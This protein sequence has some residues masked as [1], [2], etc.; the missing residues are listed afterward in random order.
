MRQ[1]MIGFR[2]EVASAGPYASL[3]LT[4]DRQPHQLLISQFL[5]AGYSSWRPTNIVKA[6]KA[7]TLHADKSIKNRV[8]YERT[9]D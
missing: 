7:Y 8:Y 3:H 5:Q 2:G 9:F 4:P 1:E 6:L